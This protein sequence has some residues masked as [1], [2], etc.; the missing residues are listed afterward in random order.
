[1]E[2]N[3][4]HSLNTEF[5]KSDAAKPSDLERH[6]QTIRDRAEAQIADLQLAADVV[7]EMGY[8]LNDISVAALKVA[9]DEVSSLNG[10]LHGD[11]YKPVD[12]DMAFPDRDGLKNYF[13]RSLP[14]LGVKPTP[15]PDQASLDL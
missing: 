3:S 1:M 10:R 2:N 7:Q 9:I 4:P 5:S 14:R 12:P 6:F 8:D 13:A 11:S 15:K